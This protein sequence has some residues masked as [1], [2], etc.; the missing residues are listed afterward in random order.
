MRDP[1]SAEIIEGPEPPVAALADFEPREEVPPHLD[2]AVRGEIRRRLRVERG[3][4]PWWTRTPAVAAVS[5]SVAAAATV[6]FMFA[7]QPLLGGDEGM[8]GPREKGL[9]TASVAEVHLDYLVQRPGD[10]SPARLNPG[11]EVAVGDAVYLRA[12][13]TQP[14]SLT[15]LADPPD[16]GWEALVTQ[17]GRA[18]ANDLQRDGRLQVFYVTEA[19]LYRFAAV[20][21]SEQ[22]PEDWN[23]GEGIAPEVKPLGED[24]E[25]A[26]VEIEAQQ[27]N[28]PP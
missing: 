17:R 14:G 20:W 10:S 18:G 28:E 5:A 4:R 23:P 16:A 12:D 11:G 22:P 26:W 27:R 19:G 9:H 3:K 1:D 13:L 8:D 6:V 25:V 7:I 24:V 2:R 21:S 15:F